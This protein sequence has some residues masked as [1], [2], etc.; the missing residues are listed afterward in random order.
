MNSSIMACPYYAA[1]NS[2]ITPIYR[3][4]LSS[5]HGRLDRRLLKYIE[6]FGEVSEAYNDTSGSNRKGKTSD[7]LLEEKVDMLIVSTDTV[8]QH[9][10][11]V[12]TNLEALKE[13]LTRYLTLDVAATSK[14]DHT[15]AMAI[16]AV[17]LGASMRDLSGDDEA[18]QGFNLLSLQ[19]AT[20]R[21]LFVPEVLAPSPHGVEKSS[22]QLRQVRMAKIVAMVKTKVAKWEMMRSLPNAA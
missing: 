14:L 9:G 16:V 4:A 18:N 13:D 19:V 17:Q 5:P 6:E 7:D 8:L 2:I 22:H 20:S 15:T 21:L 1:A 12:G 10:R 3:A 11:Q